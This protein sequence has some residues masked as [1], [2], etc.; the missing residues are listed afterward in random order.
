MNLDIKR[1]KRSVLGRGLG[2]EEGGPDHVHDTGEPGAGQ[3]AGQAPEAEGAPKAHAGDAPTPETEA[4]DLQADPERERKMILGEE[5]PKRLPKATAQPGGHAVRAGDAGKV[6]ALA[7]LL[8]S[9]LKGEALD[10]HRLEDTRRKRGGIRKETGTAGVIKSAAVMNESA[11]PARKR[12]AKTKNGS[13]KGNQMER[14]EMLRSPG[15]TMK[16]NKGTTARRRGRR[17]RIQTTLLCL[18]SQ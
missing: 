12:K 14:K 11:P 7:D 1:A 15:I 16:K 9:L 5:D 2:P 3:G 13:E 17:G 8:R 10:L 4:G 6:A 18:L